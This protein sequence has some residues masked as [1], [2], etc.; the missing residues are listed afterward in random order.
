MNKDDAMEDA[1]LKGQKTMAIE[2]ARGFAR[3]LV[4]QDW[5]KHTRLPNDIRLKNAAFDAIMEAV[6]GKVSGGETE[7]TLRA[8]VAAIFREWEIAHKKP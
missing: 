1:T 6:P 2:R 7:E 5:G 8:F 4:M 3:E